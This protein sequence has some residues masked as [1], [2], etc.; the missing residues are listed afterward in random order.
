VT[1]DDITKRINAE[2]QLKES[3]E[4][5]RT[6]SERTIMGIFILQDDQIK[7]INQVAATSLGYTSDEIKKLAPKG[8]LNLFHPDERELVKDIANKKQMGVKGIKNYFQIRALKKSG[9]IMW[10]ELFVQTFNYRGK[11]AGLITAIS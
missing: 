6:I 1:Y 5:F 3:E 2:S 11:P 4:K 9:D 10:I 8:Y 7:Y